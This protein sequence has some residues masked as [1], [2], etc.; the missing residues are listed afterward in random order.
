[1]FEL[2]SYEPFVVT[3]V[4]GLFG[5]CCAIVTSKL[6]QDAILLVEDDLSYML[7]AVK[8]N[9]D[10]DN[11]LACWEVKA[12]VISFSACFASLPVTHSESERKKSITRFPLSPG[13]SQASKLLHGHCSD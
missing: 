6:L 13:D 4:E 12:A 7:S 3:D 11:L 2:T 9:F 5:A 1:M 10:F 8:N